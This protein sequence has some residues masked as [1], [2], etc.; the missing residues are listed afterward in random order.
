MS[1]MKQLCR[2]SCWSLIV[3]LMT[4]IALSA[5]ASATVSTDKA[6]YSPGEA[7]TISG[8]NSNGAGYQPGETVH[9][10]ASGPNSWTASCDAVADDA[11]AWSCQVTLADGPEAVGEYG[12]TA[13]GL[14]SGVTESGT[15]LDSGF[16]LQAVIPGGSRIAVTFPGNTAGTTST[17]EAFT[18]GTCTPPRNKFNPA[19]VTTSTSAFVNVTSFGTATGNSNKLTAPL[20]VTANATTYLF[21]SWAVVGGTGAPTP[22][23]SVTTTGTAGCFSG[24]NASAP[25]FVQANYVLP[26]P[27]TFTKAFTPSSILVGGTSTLTFTLANSNPIP[28]TGAAFTDSLPAGVV[29]ATPNGLSNTCGGTATANAGSGSVALTGGTI[30]ASSNC[31]ITVSVKGTTAGVKNNTTSTLTTNEAPAGAAANASLVVIGPPVL[32]KAFSPS[33]VPVGGTTTLTFTLTNPNPTVP[34]SRITWADPFPLGLMVSPNP[35]VTNT[36]GGVPSVGPYA[37][38]VAYASASL[39][40]GG[41]CTFSVNL[42]ATSAGVK[43]NTTTI[44]A[45][46]TGIGSPATGTLTVTP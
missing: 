16:F 4:V 26:Q 15:F 1:T 10:D 18:N 40:A 7:V 39:P 41:S 21:S 32:T 25:T 46:S 20:V 27:P 37:L 19:A 8:D 6:D 42:T 45:S 36:C 13:T 11:G 3:V 38:A 33:T 17:I 12:Y 29:V 31:T 43:N 28:L 30:A 5:T 23:G 2:R 34:V 14:D 9:V 22:N 35:A 44:V 24:W